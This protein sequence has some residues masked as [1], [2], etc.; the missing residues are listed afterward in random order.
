MSDFAPV[1]SLQGNEDDGSHHRDEVQRQ[2]QDVSDQR[3]GAELLKR[4]LQDLSKFGN[5][6]ATGL[7]FSAL[8]DKIGGVL[9]H[10]GS[11]EGV[12]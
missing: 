10:E 6:I 5:R 2:I 8:G 3:T 1:P 12:E 4:T 11:V 9:R 7:Q